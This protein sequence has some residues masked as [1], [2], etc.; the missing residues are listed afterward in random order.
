MTDTVILLK[1]IR[2]ELQESKELPTA[3]SL[4]KAMYLCDIAEHITMATHHLNFAISR[5]I[6]YRCFEKQESDT[7]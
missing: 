5:L 1:N 2:D 4:E 3:N 6:A 7:E